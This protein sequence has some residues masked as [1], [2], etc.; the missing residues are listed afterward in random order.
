M[1]HRKIV[2]Q[3]QNRIK[4]EAGQFTFSTTAPS[5]TLRKRTRNGIDLSSLNRI[6]EWGPDYVRVE[7]RITFHAL[8]HETLKRKLIPPV[9]PEFTSIT[10]GGAVSGSAL[11]SSS[12]RYGQVSDCCLEYEV[13]LGNGELV[14]ASPEENADL[15]YGL[16]GSYGTVGIITAIKL[17]LIKAKEFV[18]ITS[19][20]LK[21]AELL[22]FLKKP[23]EDDFIEGIVLN[24]EEGVALTGS[25]TNQ[26][27]YPLFQ[28]NHYWSPWYIEAVTKKTNQE[29][30]MPLKEYLF[31]LDRGAFWMGKHVLSIPTLLRLLFHLGVPQMAQS[32]LFPSLFL[33]L[34]FGW[35]LSSRRLYGIWHRIPKNISENLFFIHDF[36]IPF[37]AVETLFSPLVEKTQIFPIWLCPVKGTQ[38][39]QLFAP[40]FGNPWL[41]NIG[42][43]GIPDS[44]LTIRELS[45]ELENEITLFGG[46]KMLYSYTYYDREKFSKIYDEIHYQ[47]LRKKYFADQ[48]FPHIYNKVMI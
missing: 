22:N 35:A 1:D 24:S 23:H 43:Y 11:E 44:P 7:S 6:L 30:C 14:N 19:R 45:S 13:I 5:N 37:P 3:I 15:F 46:R 2:Q 17:Y 4:T 31:R 25:M 12:H 27:Q 8:C 10:V 38:T 9:V 20:L 39:P 28:Q 18:H 36:Y 33:R 47:V 29:W 32:T 26:T 42:L 41:L 34:L 40:H 16:S 48:A 21:N